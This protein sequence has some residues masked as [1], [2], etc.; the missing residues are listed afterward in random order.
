M[1]EMAK[2][3]EYGDLVAEAY[4]VSGNGL[5]VSLYEKS[6]QWGR[7]T[8]T[9]VEWDKWGLHDKKVEN[10]TDWTIGYKTY[11]S[12]AFGVTITN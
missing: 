10:H 8:V 6:V 11:L 12:W 3:D 5:I 4:K 1:I 9:V 7:C 2:R